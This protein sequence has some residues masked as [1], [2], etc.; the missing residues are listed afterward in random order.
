MPTGKFMPDKKAR[1]AGN[2]GSL[3]FFDL[4]MLPQP[5]LT[6]SASYGK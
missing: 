1:I 4:E 6:E 5:L 3:G 2:A